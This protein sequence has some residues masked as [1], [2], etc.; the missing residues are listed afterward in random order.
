MASPSA[1]VMPSVPLLTVRTPSCLSAFGA[2]RSCLGLALD[3]WTTAEIWAPSAQ[4]SSRPASGDELRAQRAMES[5]WEA[6]G[7]DGPA[8]R[9]LLHNDA[10]PASIVGSRESSIVAG[11]VAGNELVGGPM[12]QTDLLGVGVKEGGRAEG[13]AASLL[14]GL[15]M[16]SS[17]DEKVAVGPVRLPLGITLVL[18]LME[19]TDVGAS[20]L[21]PEP[22]PRPELDGWRTA[23]LVNAMAS[24]RLEQLA[25]YDALQPAAFYPHSPGERLTCAGAMIGG[26]L[27]A[28]PADDGRALVALTQG[29]EMTI[30]YEMAEAARQAGLQGATKIVKPSSRGAYIT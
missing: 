20:A 22:G 8:V 17:W 25:S 19:N 30:V 5:V 2:A 13:L 4:P 28:L 10:S 9:V 21:L 7:V 24:S 12:Q 27:A 29:R 11:L 15:Q 3:G 23:L 6:A 14:G 1:L 26:A 18:F 16:A